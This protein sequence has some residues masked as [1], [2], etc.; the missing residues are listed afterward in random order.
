[1]KD[2]LIVI[3]FYTTIIVILKPCFNIIYHNHKK[4]L[5][6]DFLS[7]TKDVDKDED[8][9]EHDY[10]DHHFDD[11]EDHNKHED[12]EEH[13][14]YNLGDEKDEHDDEPVANVD[15]ELKKI[16]EEV[17]GVDDEEEPEENHSETNHTEERTDESAHANTSEVTNQEIAELEKQLSNQ[18][19]KMKLL[20]RQ[21]KE[22]KAND[23]TNLVG[24]LK[25][26]IYGKE[27]N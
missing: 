23:K 14:D 19:K 13:E 20:L 8:I 22:L 26:N 5:F 10:H 17:G 6:A 12:I 15:E 3:E 27:M 9:E 18:K 7:L 21:I 16:E 24:I 1:M 2:L 25:D 4:S 11:E